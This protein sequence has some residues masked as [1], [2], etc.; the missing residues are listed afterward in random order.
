MLLSLLR[1]A[2]FISRS[3]Y[4][5]SSY[6]LLY[7]ILEWVFLRKTKASFSKCSDFFKRPRCKIR[8]EWGLGLLFPN[9]LLSNLQEESGLNQ[10]LEKAQRLLLDLSLS[11]KEK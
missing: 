10:S 5:V 7:R 3:G 2:L 6:K 11:L 4:K 9:R 1:T 8:M